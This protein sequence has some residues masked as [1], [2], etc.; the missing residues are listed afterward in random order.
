MNWDAIGAIAELVG[1]SGVIGSLL[2]LAGQVRMSSRASAVESKME[3]TALLC[4]FI[5][6]VIND[7]DLLDLQRRGIS[8]VELLTKTEYIRFSNMCLKA[9]W[10]FS[11]S[12]FQ[13]R[14][15]TITEDDFY[16]T[17]AVIHYWLRGRGCR[18]WW[19]KFGRAALSPLFAKFIDTEIGK[20]MPLVVKSR[21]ISSPTVG[22]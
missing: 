8:D 22:T 11:A 7:P 10:M 5:D 12:Y 14:S 17:R 13:Y 9:F 16:E 2:Y 3:S 20:M 1:A 6:S 18:M 19:E 15:G 4:N 21:P